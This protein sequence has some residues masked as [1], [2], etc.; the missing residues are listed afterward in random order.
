M[1]RRDLVSVG[2]IHGAHGV[3]GEVK[4]A[5]FTEQPDKIARYGPLQTRSGSVIEIAK[6]RPRTDG[7][8]ATLKGVAD[9]DQAEALKGTE[10]FVAREL[11]PEPSGD[12]V[13]LGDLVGLAVWL[14]DGVQLGQV[15]NVA[16]Y[17]AGPLLD[18]KPAEQKETVLI[19]FSKAFIADM[20]VKGGKITVELPEGFLDTDER[21]Q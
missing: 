10:L 14:K 8:I 12:E 18:V 13:Y 21:P 17:G 11:L 20:D 16:D 15:V 7:F 5:S 19:P 9:R 6:L 3:R 4:L 2:M 1:A